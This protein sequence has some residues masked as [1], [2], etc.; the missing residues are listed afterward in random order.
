MILLFIVDIV[1]YRMPPR[2]ARGRAHGRA[3]A[4]RGHGGHNSHAEESDVEVEQSDNY[5]T[6]GSQYTMVVDMMVKE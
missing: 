2:V 5:G 6:H 4:R 1:L 3:H